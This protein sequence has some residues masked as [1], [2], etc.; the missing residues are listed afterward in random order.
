MAVLAF[1]V[2]AFFVAAFLAGAFFV[3]SSFEEKM[4]VMLPMMDTALP[5]VE[6][7]HQCASA[8]NGS[9]RPAWLEICDRAALIN[10]SNGACGEEE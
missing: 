6:L 9:I 8:R 1:A 2:A 10:L 7:D 3:A 4:P 5:S